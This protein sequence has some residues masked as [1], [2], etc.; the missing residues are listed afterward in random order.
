MAAFVARGS[1]P[2]L[3]RPPRLR[4]LR[5]AKLSGMWGSGGFPP[6]TIKQFTSTAAAM[7]ATNVSSLKTSEANNFASAQVRA[8]D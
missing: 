3:T 5:E 4:S 8:Q 1:N 6:T 2:T 7:S